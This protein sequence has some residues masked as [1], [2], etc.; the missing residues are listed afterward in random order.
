M[1][2]KVLAA[3]TVPAMSLAGAPRLVPLVVSA[4]RVLSRVAVPALTSSPP[5]VPPL[6]TAL[7][8]TV[9]LTRLML[10]PPT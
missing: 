1:R 8:A 7:R 3:S 10:P 6:A 4:T 5:P 2:L 9:A